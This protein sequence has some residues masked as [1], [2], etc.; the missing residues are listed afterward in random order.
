M[1]ESNDF[2]PDGL[3]PYSNGMPLNIFY[4]HDGWIDDNVSILI[5][6]ECL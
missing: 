4:R 5:L 1:Y 2:I 6:M 3:N